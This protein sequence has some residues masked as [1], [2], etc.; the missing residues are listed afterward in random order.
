MNTT[1]KFFI[2]LLLV[3][4]MMTTLFL[5][6]TRESEDRIPFTVKTENLTD[7]ADLN[8]S[9]LQVRMTNTL[10]R[11]FPGHLNAEGQTTL[12]ITPG[13]YS[14]VITGQIITPDGDPATVQGT[15]VGS[16]TVTRDGVM[17][18]TVSVQDRSCFRID[19]VD[20]T[21]FLNEVTVQ[22]TL[23][24]APALIIREIYFGGGPAFTGL[25]PETGDSVFANWN[26]DQYVEVFN[27]SNRVIYLDSLIIGG[28]APVN[29]FSNTNPNNPWD[30]SGVL[31]F[32]GSM[33]MVPGNGTDHPLQP[34]E[35]VVF[36]PEAVDHSAPPRNARSGLQLNR[37]HFALFNAQQ[38]TGQTEP[39][40]G[41][42]VLNMLTAPAGNRFTFSVSSP[43]VVI[44][45]IPNFYEEW[46]SQINDF[47]VTQPGSTAQTRHWTIRPEWIIDGVDVIIPG[48]P[49]IIKRLPRNID[50]TF[51][52]LDGGNTFGNA[53]TRRLYRVEN[54]RNIYQVT[55]NSGADF[56]TARP[57]PRL[58]P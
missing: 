42:I 47:H 24:N 39:A 19:G 20:S 22:L 56:V 54:G 10:G 27:N 44:A 46:W 18:G 38:H 26:R 14:I 23:V 31:A 21:L 12:M 15:T 58:R 28:I 8:M 25:N 53:L 51:T 30:G 2:P 43:A 48:A 34:G 11:S 17:A 52:Y 1:Q 32:S 7:I 29:G 4:A 6:C 33:W 45:R 55:R 57:N 41:V 3:G 50:L 49:H 5:G 13:T 40:P 36:A 35:G 37:A 9:T 16:F